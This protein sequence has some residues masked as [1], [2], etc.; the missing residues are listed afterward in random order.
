M[1]KRLTVPNLL[2]DLAR[3]WP[4]AAGRVQPGVLLLYR[5]RDQL[6]DDLARVIEPFG[7][8]PADLDVL[9]AL[10]TRPPP[11]ELT[12][13]VLYRSLLLSSGGLTKILYRVASAGLIDRPPNPIDGRSRLVRLTAL[14]ERLLEEVLEPVVAHEQRFLRPLGPD[15]QRELT[16]LLTKLVADDARETGGMR[17]GVPA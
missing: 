6:Y 4:E 7:L 15:E 8:L 14:G 13:T 2:A 12:P 17:T 3:H 11:R 5:A 9:V 1:T 16:R 10:R